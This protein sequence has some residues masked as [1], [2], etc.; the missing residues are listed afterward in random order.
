MAVVGFIY[1]LNPTAGIFELLPDNLPIVGN[2][3]EGA[4]VLMILAGIVETAEGKKRRKSGK[5]QKPI[6]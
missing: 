2:L 3:D 1:F 6:G 5:Q 4:S